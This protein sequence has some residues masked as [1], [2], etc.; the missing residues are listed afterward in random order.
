MNANTRRLVGLVILDGWGLNPKREGNAIRLAR[1][2]VMDGLSARYPVSTLTTCGEAVGLPSGQM[3]NSEVGHLNLGAGRI[4]YQDLT[5]IDKAV[6]DGAL[7]EIPE[8][9]EALARAA[10]GG[11][12]HFM[13]LLSPGGVHSHQEHL[14]AMA[15][16]AGR[17]GVGRIRVHA[18]LDGRDTPPR[19]A[20]SSIDALEK[21][22][23]AVPGAATATISGRFYAMDRDKRWERTEAAYRAMVRGEG[24]RAA[25]GPAALRA[26]YEANEDDEFV[27]PT[28]LDGADGSVRRGDTVIAFNFRPDRMRQICRALGDPG[29][30]GFARSE[31]PLDLHLVCM[32]EYDETFRFPVLF[33][34]EPLR[35]TIGETVSRA[36]VRQLRIAETEKY[37]HVTYFFNG[38]EEK[39]FEG[40][41]RVL[42]PSP[43]VKTYDLKPEMSA[44]EVTDEVVK[45]LADDRY[46]FF[47]LN[48]ANPDMVGHTGK[49]DA[50]VRAVETVDG[51]LG[52]VVEAVSSRGGLA[53]V[54]AD[55]GNAEQMIDETTGGPHTAHTLNP[56]PFLVTGGEPHSVRSGIL[57][58]VA[59]TLLAL[60]GIPAPP[61]MTGESLLSS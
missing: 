2:P 13:G 12:L 34:D 7:A 16:L 28:V 23:A 1:T 39:P 37:A 26:A 9:K 59:P 61:E 10:R 8:L 6:R 50:A 27:Q 15:R 48:Y 25:S 14:F 32:T 36:G 40:E 4:V 18:F 43:K 56:V 19:S 20:G 49:I 41:D 35:A 45:R 24:R 44:V 52:R 17:A 21:T 53:L 46:G 33:H 31:W 30:D 60:L 5:R 42:I 22:V 47:V 55:H 29:F 3:G 38:S 57:A 54:T 58:D 51:C 11:T